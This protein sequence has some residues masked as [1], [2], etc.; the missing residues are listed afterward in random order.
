MP[1]TSS[2]LALG[3]FRIETIHPIVPYELWDQAIGNKEAWIRPLNKLYDLKSHGRSASKVS[4]DAKLV[5][6]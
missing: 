5:V 2:N 3:H 1:Y 6:L 4:A